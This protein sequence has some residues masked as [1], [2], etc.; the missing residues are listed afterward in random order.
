MLRHL[1]RL[2]GFGSASKRPAL[3]PG[4]RFVVTISE[5]G[6]SCQRPHGEK[7]SVDWVDVNAVL[8]KTTDEGP[9]LPD[10]FWVLVGDKGGCVIPQGATGEKALMER[11]RTLVGFDNEAVIKAMQCAENQ[12][13]LCWKRKE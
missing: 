6:V 11:L 9:F 2:L 12:G 3:D 13:F 1:R 4:S 10:V 8:I 5:K 7:E